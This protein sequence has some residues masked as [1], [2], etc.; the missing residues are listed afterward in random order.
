LVKPLING[1]DLIKKLKLKPGPKIGKLLIIAREA[2]LRGKI[3][4]KTQALK[5]LKNHL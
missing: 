5:L 3:K 2:Q 4:T 1:H